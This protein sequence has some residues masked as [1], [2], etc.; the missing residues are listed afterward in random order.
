M[1]NYTVIYSF[2]GV[3]YWVPVM[4]QSFS[5]A[6]ERFLGKFNTD[7]ILILAISEN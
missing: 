4:A 5:D 3:R 6:R 1:K 2:N 7:N